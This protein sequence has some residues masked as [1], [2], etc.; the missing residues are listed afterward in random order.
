MVS[1]NGELFHREHGIYSIVP[2]VARLLPGVRITPVVIAIRLDWR[3]H[4]AEWLSLIERA[5]VGGR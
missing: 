4:S 2:F 1:E 5:T 3:T